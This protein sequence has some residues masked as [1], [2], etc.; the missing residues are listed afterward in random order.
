MLRPWLLCVWLVALCVTADITAADPR[1][2]A[3]GAV[4]TVVIEN[5]QYNRRSC[6]CT[7]AS[8]SCG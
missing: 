5:M 4:H 2:P 1:P 7:A 6:A 3:K 8:E